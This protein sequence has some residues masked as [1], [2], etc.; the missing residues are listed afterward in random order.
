VSPTKRLQRSDNE[1]YQLKPN[2]HKSH[3]CGLEVG[4]YAVGACDSNS[5]KAKTPKGGHLRQKKREPAAKRYTIEAHAHSV[6]LVA[7]RQW[8]T[9]HKHLASPRG[10]TFACAV[11]LFYAGKLIVSSRLGL[12]L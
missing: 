5:T 2:W 3:C 4:A 8:R 11:L 10:V 7:E 12:V 6:L 1:M 9:G